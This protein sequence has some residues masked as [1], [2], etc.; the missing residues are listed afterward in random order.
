[1]PKDIFKQIDFS[2]G[3]NTQVNIK[4]LEE[5]ELYVADDIWLIGKV[6]LE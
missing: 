3:L 2:G 1:M 5:N 6:A 4:D